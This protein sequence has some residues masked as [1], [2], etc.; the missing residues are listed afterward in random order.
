MLDWCLCCYTLAEYSGL[1]QIEELL[2]SASAAAASPIELVQS[3]QDIEY[4]AKGC[5][6]GSLT[7]STSEHPARPAENYSSWV[8]P[9]WTLQGNVHVP[10]IGTS[11]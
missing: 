1:Y 8:S 9:L 2:E 5:F 6:P 7:T 4:P 10:V 11:I 3:S